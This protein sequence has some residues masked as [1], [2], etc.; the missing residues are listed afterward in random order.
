MSAKKAAAHVPSTDPL[1]ASIVDPVVAVDAE[2]P[3]I[4][5]EP[6]Q[7]ITPD[8][9]LES[10]E[11][12]EPESA[13]TPSEAERQELAE[14][15]DKLV[16]RIRATS[17]DYSPPPFSPRRLVQL[18]SDNLTQ[19]SPQVSLGFLERLRSG[20]VS[21]VFDADTWKGIWYVVNFSIQSQKDI[22]KRRLAGEY[23]TD[24]W[25]YDPEVVEAV[26]PF[27]DFMYR[28][29]WRVQT[30]GMENIPA[31]NRAMLVSN[32]SGQLPFDG[33][34]IGMAVNNE[35]PN[36]R[37]VRA[38]YASW[39]P[40]LPVIS[41]LF[42]KMGQSLAN[43]DNGIRLLE[44]ENLIAVFPEG[45][46]GVQKLYKDRYKLARFG[47]GGFVRMA[48]KTGAPM[49][50]V[51]VVGAEETYISFANAELIAKLIGFPFFP[52]TITW[53]WLGLLGFIP[54]PTKWYIDIGEPV[55][56]EHYG[57]QAANNLLLVS[58]LSDQ[59]RN[60]VQNMIYA[61]LA[62]R[63]SVIFG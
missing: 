55:P 4:L 24:E 56:T 10:V 21:D 43:E 27:F 35:H 47:R 25:G 38:L 36:R 53:P 1:E 14:E 3:D 12:I 11:A 2:R 45:I 29:Y 42:V 54:I 28:R 33:S 62:A 17:P 39:F 59:M 61:R 13:K 48:L 44:Q 37:L 60:Q 32:H 50:P 30:T 63:R 26:R 34:M 8:Q 20:L 7:T 15:I 23:E 58:Q 16:E 5:P 57:G 6:I 19:L 31:E 40:T 18:I 52:I 41:T 49:I 46:K 9:N 51:S 22:I